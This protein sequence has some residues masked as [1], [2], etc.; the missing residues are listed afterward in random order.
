MGLLTSLVKGPFKGIKKVA[1]L[2]NKDDNSVPIIAVVRTNYPSAYEYFF[3]GVGE[4][5][6]WRGMTIVW[7]KGTKEEQKKKVMEELRNTI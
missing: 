4:T 5:S 6:Y 3:E 2:I 7:K 1:G